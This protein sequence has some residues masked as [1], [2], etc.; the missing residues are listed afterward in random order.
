MV[1]IFIPIDVIFHGDHEYRVI[2][3]GWTGK[4]PTYRCLW[5]IHIS[6]GWQITVFSFLYHTFEPKES[7]IRNL[8]EKLRRL[9]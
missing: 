5:P 8:R 6:T 7:H 1:Y 9:V 4:W 3:V 2:L